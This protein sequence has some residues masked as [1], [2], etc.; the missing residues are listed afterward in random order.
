[1][2]R[3]AVRR[4]SLALFLYRLIGV[5]LFEATGVRKLLFFFPNLFEHWFLFVEARKCFFPALRLDTPGRIAVTL[6]LLYVPK[7]GQEWVL[8]F[9]QAQPWGWFKATVLR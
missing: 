2:V 6:A 3:A 7:F 8:H 1:M 9:A 4:T 5:I